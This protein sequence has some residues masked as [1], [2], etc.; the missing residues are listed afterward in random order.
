VSPPAGAGERFEIELPGDPAYVAT[1]RMFA[2]SLA[3]QVGVEE[4]MLDDLKLAVSEACARA[5]G[6]AAAGDGLRVKAHL[7]EDR[8]VFEIPQGSGSAS[9]PPTGDLAP[10]L[11]L[12]LV[13]VLFDDA[14]VIQ[15][16]DGTPAV[17]FSVRVQ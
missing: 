12:E 2:S 15:D 5:L 6:F 10:G 3:R 9:P 4:E 7:A 16:D 11:S 13:T 1:A 8:L 14:E 17:R